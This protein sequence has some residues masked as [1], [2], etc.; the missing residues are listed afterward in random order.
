VSVEG[1]LRQALA[2]HQDGQLR[3]ALAGYLQAL[4]AEPDNP[5]ALNL[6]GVAHAALDELPEAVEKLERCVAAAPGFADAHSNLALAYR[7]LGRHE[8]ALAHQ[9]QVLELSPGDP[10]ALNESGITLRRLGRYGK[11]LE[12][13]DAAVAAAPGFAQAHAN[14]GNV[15]QDLDRMDEAAASYRQAIENGGGGASV[16]RGLGNALQRSHSLDE[17]VEAYRQSVAVDPDY[18]PVLMDLGGALVES[19]DP[20]EGARWLSKAASLAELDPMVHSNLGM[21][22]HEMGDYPAALESFE[23]A[24]NLDPGN[25][26]ALAF[27]SITLHEVGDTERWHAIN[28]LD[29][30]VREMVLPTPPEF[31]SLDALNDSLADFANSHP[32]VWRG[33]R[34]GISSE[35]FLDGAGPPLAL[36]ESIRR[37]VQAYIDELPGDS[38]HAFIR[39]R[40]AQFLLSGWCNV[41]DEG[42]PSHIHPNAWLSGAYYVRADAVLDD[43]DEGP[44]GC[45][46]VGPPDEA[47]YSVADYPAR[48]FRPREGHMVVFPSYVWHRILPFASSE[49]RISYA[50]DVIPKA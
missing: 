24:L 41:L 16:W 4:Q 1:I 33:R 7:S 11:A 43:V 25:T 50:F 2:L 28:G 14:R 30:L 40:P 10:G 47:H 36:R 9:R 3:E 39:R 34:R 13:F 23:R 32:S 42:A 6:A 15:L 48:V 49:R 29:S 8:A 21:A 38:Q 17:A 5:S 31:D 44:D 27:Q 18:V 22:L 46:Q 37:A 45:L 26:H 20:Q 35:L 12:A 19:G